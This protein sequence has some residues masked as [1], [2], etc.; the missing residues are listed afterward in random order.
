MID[1]QPGETVEDRREPGLVF[2]L[3]GRKVRHDPEAVA[4]EPLG[5]VQR[6]TNAVTLRAR[7]RHAR[8]A[9]QRAQA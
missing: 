7:D 4:H 1:G 5:E 3:S 9:V 8:I 6:G 2:H